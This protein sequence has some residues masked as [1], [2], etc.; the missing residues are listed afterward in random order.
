MN[1]YIIYTNNMNLSV[2]FLLTIQILNILRDIVM[3][4]RK[5]KK[6]RSKMNMVEAILNFL[7]E[8]IK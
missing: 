1:T 7:V 3:I 5:N 8:K 6:V 4:Q 2:R